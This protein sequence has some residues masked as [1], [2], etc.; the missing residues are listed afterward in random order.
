MVPGT[1][2]DNPVI[3]AE[4]NKTPRLLNMGFL[5]APYR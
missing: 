3:P 1:S 4:L 2:Y 5:L